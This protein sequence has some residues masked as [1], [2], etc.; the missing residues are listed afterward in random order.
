[1]GGTFGNRL[2]LT[3]GEAARILGVSP[4]TVNRWADHGRIPCSHTLGGQRRFR[5]DVIAAVGSSMSLQ[6]GTE[7]D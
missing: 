3:S 7:S 6:N 4:R 2:Y 1:M 5:P